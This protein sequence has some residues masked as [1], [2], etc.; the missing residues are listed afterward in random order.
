VNQFIAANRYRRYPLIQT[1]TTSISDRIMVDLQ[2]VLSTKF[3]VFESPTTGVKLD[4]IVRSGGSATFT[5]QIISTVL[6]GYKLV[7]VV[8]ETAA[9]DTRVILALQNSSSTPHPE[10]GYGILMVGV[11]N[12]LT[13]LSI[14]TTTV[15]EWIDRATIRLNVTNDQLV[16]RVA[17]RTRPGPSTCAESTGIAEVVQLQGRLV[18]T[19]SDCYEITT[20]PSEDTTQRHMSPTITGDTTTQVAMVA[21]TSTHDRFQNDTVATIT[22]HLVDI[23]DEIPA[24][25]STYD[26]D[27]DTG[28]IDAQRVLGVGHNLDLTGDIA[29][30][31]VR[32]NYRL[33]GGLGM[34]CVGVKGYPSLGVLAH[35]CIKSINGVHSVGG[36][37]TLIPGTGVGLIP[38]EDG[39]KLIVLMGIQHLGQVAP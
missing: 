10:L 9:D 30:N 6:T 12:D 26:A 8:S 4:T 7:G 29:Q 28:P 25:P 13:A 16:I 19:V 36:H 39:H 35:D 3:S 24:L 37:L 15:D 27:T 1:A 18:Q 20:A 22:T 33:N 14:G 32:F 17:N 5:F 11:A 21:P 34:D 2:L 23:Q 31:L 38:D